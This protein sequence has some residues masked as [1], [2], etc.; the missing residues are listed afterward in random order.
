MQTFLIGFVLGIA[1]AIHFIFWFRVAV[2]GIPRPPLWKVALLGFPWA[3]IL[4]MIVSPFLMVHSLLK[5]IVTPTKAS[6]FERLCSRI[7]IP[8][9]QI[10]KNLYICY[11]KEESLPRR[12]WGVRTVPD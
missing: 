3:I 11:S 4:V 6:N 2:G 7:D 10:G 12:L 5:H 1:F 9:K 8:R